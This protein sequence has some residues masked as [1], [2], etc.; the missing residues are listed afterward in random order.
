MKQISNIK[1]YWNKKFF[2]PKH[3]FKNEKIIYNGSSPSGIGQLQQ[4]AN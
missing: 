4:R 3:F 2:N 1:T